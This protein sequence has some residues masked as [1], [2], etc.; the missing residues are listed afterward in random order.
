MFFIRSA[1]PIESETIK[2]LRNYNSTEQETYVVLYWSEVIGVFGI[3]HTD[4]Y[5]ELVSVVLREEYRGKDIMFHCLS[6]FL[7]NETKYLARVKTGNPP[8]NR[9][10]SKLKFNMTGI[11]SGI[12]TWVR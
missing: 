9:M 8:V 11:Q 7:N 2:E 3:N 4:S 6:A 5:D 1:E 12:C 10:L